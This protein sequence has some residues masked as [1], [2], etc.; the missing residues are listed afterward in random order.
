MPGESL[1]I[2]ETA[3][4][5]TNVFCCT[6]YEG[7]SAAMAGA[8]DKAE[9]R[10]PVP[11]HIDDDLSRGDLRPGS[12]DNTVA[13]AIGRRSDLKRFQRRLEFSGH[14]YYAAAASLCGA[15]GEMNTIHQMALG[16]R[17]HPP[18]DGSDL[19]GS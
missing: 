9:F 4:E 7:S 15:I 13:T 19:L 10:I 12:L 3:T 5:A 16:V 17:Y 8:A 11:K 14:R 6:G 1:N 2:S 18:R